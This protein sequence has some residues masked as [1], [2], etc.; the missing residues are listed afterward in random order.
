MATAMMLHAFT[1]DS[2]ACWRNRRANEVLF[3]AQND[4]GASFTAIVPGAVRVQLLEPASR[5]LPVISVT[6]DGE[7][8]HAQLARFDDEAAIHSGV[9][10]ASVFA[11]VFVAGEE[12]QG[13]ALA[14]VA[15]DEDLPQIPRPTPGPETERD[16]AAKYGERQ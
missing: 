10:L 16:A 7:V 5:W 11:V 13:A 12:F 2:F 14:S 9:Y 1:G 3:T 6:R 8:F 4:G 15:I